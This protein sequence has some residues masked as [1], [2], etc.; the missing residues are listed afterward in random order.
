MLMQ[1]D[2]AAPLG[3]QPDPDRLRALI[4]KTRE[5]AIDRPKLGAMLSKLMERNLYGRG[6]NRTSPANDP[7]MEWVGMPEFE[8]EDLSPYRT[9]HVHFQN[10]EDIQGFAQLVE[11]SITE[12]TR[13]LWYP[14]LIETKHGRVVSD[15]S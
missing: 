11:Q 7:S 15:E 10:E 5:R 3:A 13:M 4:E 1:I 12:K 8:Q 2:N 14:K 6:V 9:I